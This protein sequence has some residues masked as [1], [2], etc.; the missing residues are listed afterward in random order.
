MGVGI[1]IDAHL[2]P[3]YNVLLYIELFR[4]QVELVKFNDMQQKNYKLCILLIICEKYK[5]NAWRIEGT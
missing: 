1:G 3:C 2:M 4:Y 5:V